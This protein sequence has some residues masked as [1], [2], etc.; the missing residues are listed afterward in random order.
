[1]GG[2]FPIQ[3]V[4][5]VD[6]Q[7]VMNSRYKYVQK[8]EKRRMSKQKESPLYT[9]QNKFPKNSNLTNLT[10]SVTFAPPALHELRLHVVEGYP[11]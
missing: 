4:T 10:K 7:L 9:T 2:Y 8:C 3:K 6:N 5:C 11:S 1:V